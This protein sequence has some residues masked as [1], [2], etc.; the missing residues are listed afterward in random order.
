MRWFEGEITELVG[1]PRW[2]PLLPSPVLELTERGNKSRKCV[3]LE[4]A[5]RYETDE[6]KSLFR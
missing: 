5:W 3:E 2:Q 4:A 6:T 1:R